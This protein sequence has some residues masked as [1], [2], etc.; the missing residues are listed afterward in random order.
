MAAS[1]LHGVEVIETTTGPVPITV[2][3]SSVIGLV[4]TAPTWAVQAPA[5]AA[6]L[7]APT[8]VSSA[9]DA[10]NFGPL[11]QGY[12]IPY[13]LAAI[14]G[15]GAGQVITINVFNPALHFSDVVLALTFSTAGAINL[16]HM[17]ISNLSVL[18][19]TTAAISGEV[20]TFSG[21][22]ATVQLTHG[23]VQATSMVLTSSPVGKTYVQGTDYTLDARTGLVSIIAGGAIS[24]TQPV[25]VSYT[26]Y[27]GSPYSASTDY[28]LDPV[29]GVVR[30]NSGTTIPASGSVIAAFSY[31]DP[32]KVQDSNIIGGVSAG[33]YGGMQG[34]LTSYG[35]M[36]FFPK[37]LIAPGYAQNA[38]V[39][40][41][42]T[43]IAGTVRG[44]A[45]VDS[46]PSTTV[47]T[48]IANRG[49]AGNAFDTSST[50]VVLCYPQEQFFD[51]GMVPTGVTLNGTL[52]VQAQANA[53]AV[54]PYSPWVAG[55]IAARDL[56]K[57]YW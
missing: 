18:P 12:T 23:E 22:P 42:L 45:L 16:G 55:A 35:T 27:S 36:G 20:H 32:S 40:S 47:A 7:N 41:A 56:A 39:A 2:V 1:F 14:Q 26:Y 29:N 25:L 11:V 31:A 37:V 10:A 5:V 9:L 44:V 15:Q 30:L 49:V 43:T 53:N 4:G 52:P 48:A 19:T 13:A 46:P 28:T 17:G 50:R 33:A 57:G 6:S 21:T 24:N 51:T 3:K 34:W 8:L 54:G 38:D